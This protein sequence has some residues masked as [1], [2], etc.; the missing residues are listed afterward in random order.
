MDWKALIGAKSFDE[1]M[2]EAQQR[3]TDKNSG[4]TNWNNGGIFKTLT[5]VAVQ[6]LAD[7]F[8]LLV[9]KIVPMGFI[10]YA[11]GVW[12]DL[13]VKEVSIERRQAKKAVGIV[14]FGRD[15]AGPAKVI[16]AGSIVKTDTASDG[17]EL[18]YFT[19]QEVILAQDVLTAAVTVRAEFEGARY[20]VGQ[21][22]IKH[23]VTH[24]EG[25]DYVANSSNWV[26]EEGADPEDNDSLNA[27]YKLKWNELATGSTRLAYISWAMSVPG[28]LDADADDM[29]P[30]GP[31]TVNVYIVGPDGT[32]TQ[33]LIDQVLAAIALKR[34]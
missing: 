7:F 24:V 15:V 6:G 13:K 28:V 19:T 20:N 25:I 11:K 33:S 34:P 22:Y 18:R 9:D 26:T 16:P 30:R 23:L 3:L 1:L 32:P 14:T 4:I 29:N 2:A 17:Q 21:G 8:V 31:G 5:A 10:D 27:R 12:L